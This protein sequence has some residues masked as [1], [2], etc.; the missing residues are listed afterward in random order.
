MPGVD[1]GSVTSE[2]GGVNFNWN[3]HTPSSSEMRE[4]PKGDG[5]K[6]KLFTILSAVSRIRRVTSQWRHMN[7]KRNY[8]T[9]IFALAIALL[10]GSC[11]SRSLI[12][13]S[14]AGAVANVEASY[15]GPTHLVFGYDRKKIDDEQ[16]HKLMPALLSL[17][18]LEELRMAGMPITDRAVPDLLQL[19]SL[20]SLDIR[21]TNISAEGAS[22]L[23]RLPQ[24]RILVI[25]DGQYKRG[26]LDDLTRQLSGVSVKVLPF[27]DLQDPQH[28]S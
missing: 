19:R 5:M 22:S 10:S 18:K 17:P 1:G 16:L 14:D 9:C 23:R 26:D 28:K 6:R 27:P 20:C 11:M 21:A 8:P 13:L 2:D 24:L 4:C 15:V 7:V 12:P 25:T 3:N